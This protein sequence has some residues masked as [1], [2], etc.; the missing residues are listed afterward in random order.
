M[1]RSISVATNIQTQSS[2]SEFAFPM[3][4]NHPRPSSAVA[5]ARE[6]Y[7]NGATRP[8]KYEKRRTLQ[9]SVEPSVEITLNDVP[10]DSD[11]ETDIT[12]RSS[13]CENEDDV[14][15]DPTPELDDE[16]N[17]RQYKTYHSQ[18]W[19]SK[20]MV[21]RARS[22]KRSQS[23]VHDARWLSPHRIRRPIPNFGTGPLYERAVSTFG[24]GG[25]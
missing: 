25:T 20:E 2:E 12:L 3:A 6:L 22:L 11:E 7:A 17:N 8:K 15:S 23:D 4:S 18:D 21:N 14:A 24:K 19:S 1:Q 13:F 16:M 9:P 10:V 5:V